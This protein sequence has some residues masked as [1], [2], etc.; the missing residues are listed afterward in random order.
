MGVGGQGR[1]K[2]VS[3]PPDLVFGWKVK[4]VKPDPCGGRGGAFLGGAPVNEFGLGDGEGQPFGGRDAA[5]GA[6]MT[7]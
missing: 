6:V 4:V 5:E 1:G 3:K 2:P 7:L